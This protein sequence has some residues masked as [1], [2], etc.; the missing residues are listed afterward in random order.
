MNLTE[1]SEADLLGVM[2]LQEIRGEEARGAW[3]ELF[4]RHRRYLFVVVSRSYGSF[5][6][7]D[8]TVDLV[9]DTFQRAF[10]WAGRQKDADQVRTQ[11][12]A[13]TPDSTRR[14]V[15]AWLC[16]IA[17]RLFKGRYREDKTEADD[18]AEFLEHWKS[19]QDQPTEGIVLPSQPHLEAALASLSQAEAEAL[20]VSLPWYDLESR[21][22]AVPRGEAARI[23]A[24]LGT[25]P[26][27][28]RQRRH[29]AIAKIQQ[30]LEHAGYMASNQEEAS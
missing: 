9:C 1:S 24:L 28:L 17:E 5:L 29:R 13:S 2:A 22:F 14:R 27:A 7:E 21:S 25:T 20:R 12:E 11:F 4:A 30:H 23:S 10:E 16:T 26:D 8:G 6:G 15:L 3:G 18:Y 19:A